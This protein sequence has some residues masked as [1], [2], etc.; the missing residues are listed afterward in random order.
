MRVVLLAAVGLWQA[1]AQ[2]PDVFTSKVYPVLEEARCRT[3]HARDGVASATRL[4]FPE[5]DATRNRIAS[6][7]LSLRALVDTANPAKSLFV[8]KPTRRVEHTG[9]EVLKP[10]SPEDAALQQWATALASATPASISVLRAKLDAAAG[11]TGPS[12]L[13]RRLTHSQYNNTVRDLLGD[14]SKPAQRFPPEDFTDGFRNQL[15][16]Q[17][18]SPLLVETYSSAAEK[19]ALNA[20]R[21]GDVNRVI[22]CKPASATDA[23]CRDRFVRQF[24]LRAFRRPLTANELRRYT[25]A[26]EAQARSTGKFLEGARVTVEAML[27]SPKF[28]FHLEAGPDGRASGYAIASRLSYLLWDTMPDQALLDAAAKGEL[29]TP[30][31]IDRAARRLLSD[32]RAEAA[33]DEFF[34]QWLRLERV[35]NASK[36][37]R[38]FPEFSAEMGAAMAEETRRLL[39]HLVWND[40]DFTELFTARYSFL[41]ADL[42]TLYGVPQP[43]AEFELTHFP[44]S[45][46]RA[47][48]LGQGSFLAAAAGPVETSPTARGI[49]VRE[50]LLCQHVPPPPPNVVVDIDPKEDKPQTRKQRLAQHVESP[51]CASCHRLMDPIGLGLESF[52]A[53]GKFRAKETLVFT[54]E[55]NRTEPRK[56]DLP[57]ETSGEIAGIGGSQFNDA[58]GLGRILAASPVCQ[59]CIVRQFFRYSFGRQE[60]AA[61][62]PAIAAL[63]KRFRES[64]F[65]FREL[66]LG[67]VRS[68]EFS[69][70]LNDNR[71]ESASVR[72]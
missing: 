63:T 34:H 2:D 31:G 45:T 17:S 37:R 51:A 48:L 50:Q 21:A 72:R 38:R 60:S 27:Q 40:K 9:G 5:K 55:T 65:R 49:F 6:F 54:S 61:D 24:G 68:P 28:L 10:G 57:L 52:D 64:G 58:A 43:P 30:E 11:A 36:E 71:V 39:R 16:N 23:V 14:H 44:A 35:V 69:R 4:H 53:I 56:V 67:L 26:F 25:A 22:P 41:S 15:R 62:H 3:C 46:P 19:L 12:Q 42:A 13:V 7:G 59:E 33:L 1:A 8:A 20:F 29:S 66:V 32:R 18:M 47:G 70:G